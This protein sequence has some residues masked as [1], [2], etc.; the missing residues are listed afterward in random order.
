M[1]DADVNLGATGDM[2]LG[3]FARSALRAYLAAMD[4]QRAWWAERLRETEADLRLTGLRWMIEAGEIAPPD[5][6]RPNAPE[7]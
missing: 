5:W 3:P 7:A 4:E 1:D 2:V 6:Y